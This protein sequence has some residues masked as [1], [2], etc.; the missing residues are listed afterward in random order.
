[1]RRT[2]TKMYVIITVKFIKMQDIRIIFIPIYC[3]IIF[4]SMNRRD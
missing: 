2:N 3:D 4:F 1:M